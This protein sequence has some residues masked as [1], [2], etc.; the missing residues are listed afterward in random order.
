MIDVFYFF[1]GAIFGGA[2]GITIMSIM[3]INR[4]CEYESKM[5]E[6]TEK[7]NKKDRYEVEG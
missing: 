7:I 5:E 2:L 6:L 3:Q 4:I 1:C